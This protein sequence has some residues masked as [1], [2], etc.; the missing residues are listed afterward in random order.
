MSEKS[1][2]TSQEKDAPAPTR[3]SV[4]RLRALA[5]VSLA[6]NDGS[7]R[8][9]TDGKGNIAEIGA[10][11]G[12]HDGW[13][14]RLQDLFGTNGAE[15]ALAQLNHILKLSR[16]SGQYDK[17]KANCLLSAIEAARPANEIEAGLALQ[18]AITHELAMQAVVRAQR[19]DQ[20][21]QYGSAAAWQ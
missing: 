18:M 1:E 20:I 14:L 21:H 17:V 2:T 3:P 6:V 10:P 7:T 9:E 19:V 8:L 4:Q 11:H 13:M 16:G 12:D 5:F 15:Y